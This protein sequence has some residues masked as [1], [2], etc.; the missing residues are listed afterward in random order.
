MLNPVNKV[1]FVSNAP[2]A[3]SAHWTFLSELGE[4][5]QVAVPCVTVPA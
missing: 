2:G 3:H 5:L 1:I 4:H